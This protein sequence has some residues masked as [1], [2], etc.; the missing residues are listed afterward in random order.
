MWRHECTL[1]NCTN[2]FKL[3]TD[4]F[5]F[6][7]CKGVSL[8]TIHDYKGN[9]DIGVGQEMLLI[10]EE[11]GIK[12]P[13]NCTCKQI[14]RMFNR[15]GI[16]NC[17]SHRAFLVNE[18]MKNYERWKWTEKFQLIAAGQKLLASGITL[19][20]DPIHPIKSVVE[21]LIDEAIRRAEAN[22]AENKPSGP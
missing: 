18:V 17:K 7:Q 16:E 20:I 11:L 19:E 10:T 12:P 5:V 21:S 15:M 9:P 2:D 13:K 1:S 14:A 8:G 3:P 6:M 4:R 22:I